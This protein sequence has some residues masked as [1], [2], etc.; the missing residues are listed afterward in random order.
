MKDYKDLLLRIYSDTKIGIKG[1]IKAQLILMAMTFLLLSAALSFIGVD[2]AALKA[3]GIAVIDVFPVVGS[4]IVMVPWSIFKFAVGETDMGVKLA[5]TY[6]GV[7]LFRQ[8]IEPKITGDKIGVRPLYT[9]FATIAG[10]ILLGPI[11]VVAGPL[12]AVIITSAVRAKKV[13]DED[14]RR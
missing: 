13:F 5:V 7:T 11:G 2:Y 9:F 8:V 4:G 14:R 12:V 1:Y 3:L 6:V 10:S